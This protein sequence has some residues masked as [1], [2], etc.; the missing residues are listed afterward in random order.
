MLAEPSCFGLQ[1]EGLYEYRVAVE[2]ESDAERNRAFRDALKAVLL[3]VTGER[4][5]LQSPVLQQAIGNAQSYVE[6]ISYS[7]ELVE[8]SSDVIVQDQLAQV[9]TDQ[10]GV[11]ITN[12]S[13]SSV[14]EDREKRYINV[15]FAQSLLD[16]LL[17]S[18]DIPI[19]DS[20]RPSVMVWMALQNNE[21]ERSMLT[22]DS[23]PQIIGLMK[24]FAA[25]RGLPIIFPVL[26]F[27]DRRALTEDDVWALDEEAIRN[28]S[29]RYGADSVLSGRLH[30]TVSGE[31]VGLWQFIFQGQAEVFDGFDKELAP[32]LN[33]PLDRITNQLASYFA[34]V[35]ETGSLQIVRLRVEGIK[36][37]SAFSAL[38]TYIGSLGLVENVSTAEFDG[39]R[40]ELNLRLLGD[41][42]QLYE[43]IALDRDLLPITN[44]QRASESVQH[45]RW[46]R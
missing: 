15:S 7:S 21:G 27:E 36:N 26:D 1:I 20:N 6:A 35:P 22:A 4:R 11:E 23:N 18:A 31:L 46:T 16:D 5:W 34:I 38:L 14:P 8:I 9:T 33:E 25:E 24:N 44:T 40:L 45:Y 39:Q 17:A 37:L 2:N 12:F 30:F 43:V 13:I 19:W 32:Y 10:R 42:Q 3:K 28:A 41:A 29:D